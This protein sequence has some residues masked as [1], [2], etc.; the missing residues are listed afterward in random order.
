[1]T[2][3]Q[4]FDWMDEGIFSSMVAAKLGSCPRSV[5]ARECEVMS[6]SQADANRFF[7][8]NHLLGAANGQTFCVGL[9]YR[10]DLVHV[11]S[12]G[13][14]RFRSSVEWEAIRSCSR[15]GWHVQGGFSRCDSVFFREVDPVSVVSYVDLATGTGRTESMFAGW[16]A[17]RVGRPN[18]MWVRVVGGEGPA[19]VR[20]S[21]ARRVGADRLLGFEVGE[22]YPR[23]REDGSRVSNADV[24][25]MEGYVQVFD[26]GVRPF[27][28][29]KGR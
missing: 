24:L 12:Y 2:L 27:V 29:R 1:M 18:S 20:D 14:T 9:T 16:V 17:E 26:C 13:P 22:R 28:W 25:Q 10:G 4:Y 23:F 5:G 6:L 15:L 11:Q 7:R 21:A 8:E 19:Y 3:M